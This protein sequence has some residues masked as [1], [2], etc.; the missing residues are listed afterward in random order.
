MLTKNCEH[1]ANMVVYGI[2]YSKQ[3][4]E[5]RT[6]CWIACPYAHICNT[7]NN[8]GSDIYLKSEINQTNNLLS[9]KSDYYKTTEIIERYEA[10]IEVPI[11]TTDCEIMN[12]IFLANRVLKMQYM[13]NI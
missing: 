1:F 11:K 4:D 2:N 13:T 5:K 7:N 3:V 10:Q 12:T 8:K 6:R 9:K